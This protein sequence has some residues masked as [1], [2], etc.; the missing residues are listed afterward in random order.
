[1]LVSSKSVTLPLDK[2][3]LELLRNYIKRGGSVNQK[4]KKLILCSPWYGFARR[5]EVSSISRSLGALVV[6]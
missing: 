2:D 5:P 3:A 6:Y 1:V 4:G